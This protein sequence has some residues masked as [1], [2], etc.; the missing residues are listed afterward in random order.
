M[1]LMEI[2]LSLSTFLFLMFLGG[3]SVMLLV[4]EHEEIEETINETY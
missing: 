1:K 4:F 2:T 3:S